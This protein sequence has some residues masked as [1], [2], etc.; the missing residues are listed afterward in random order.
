[1]AFSLF[2]FVS[3]ESSS[4]NPKTHVPGAY[5]MTTLR[6]PRKH[7]NCRFTDKDCPERL[8]TMIQVLWVSEGDRSIH[9]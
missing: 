6:L 4:N 9:L 7:P 5:H 3:D 1:M 8:Q 2:I